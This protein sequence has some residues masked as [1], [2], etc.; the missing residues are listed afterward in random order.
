MKL[1]NN[2]A[3]GFLKNINAPAV[4]IYGNDNGAVREFEGKLTQ[5]KQSGAQADE[6]DVKTI[7]AE[8]LKEDP[9]VLLDE[10]KSMGF[11]AAKKIVRINEATDSLLANIEEAIPELNEDVFLIITAGE[12]AKKSK[13][14]A[15][16][17]GAKE[18]MAILCYKEDDFSLKNHLQ[19][20]FSDEGI[21]AEPDALEMLVTN[22]GGDRMITNSEIEKIIT[23][24]GGEKKLKFDD[25]NK[26]ISDGS[27]VT[28]IDLAFAVS[29]R[30]SKRIERSLQRA[31]AE[32]IGAVAVVR[33][34]NWHFKRLAQAKSALE[35]GGNIEG[36]MRGLYPPVFFKQVPEFKT[37]LSRWK[38]SELLAVLEK[39]AEI[40][41][42][43]KKN[44][45][46]AES[47]CRYELLS[48]AA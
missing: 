22:L 7:T 1:Y 25:V 23:Y 41:L 17:E 32:Q 13:L 27:E 29:A 43:A 9:G 31:F 5:A 28:L 46:D 45:N 4:L 30:D 10:V 42:A 21:M 14:R 35:N 48:Y 40:E 38:L 15:A 6:W 8:Q 37:A 18:L 3:A 11:F 36:A 2:K 12:L 26:L 47:C 20:R 44:A 24:L 33:M 34:V 39:T 19:A 16:F